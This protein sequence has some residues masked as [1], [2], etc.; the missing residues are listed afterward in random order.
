MKKEL[1]WITY[2]LNK[3]F[4]IFLVSYGPRTQKLKAQGSTC[5]FRDLCAMIFTQ[6]WMMD[7]FDKSWGFFRNLPAKGHACSNLAHS[8]LDKRLR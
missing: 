2:E 5:K 4:T 7:L 1:K 8:R 3:F 6:G